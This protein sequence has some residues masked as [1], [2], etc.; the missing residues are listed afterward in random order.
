M[1]AGPGNIQFQSWLYQPPSVPVY[2]RALIGKGKQNK[3][4]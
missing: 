4:K 1:L 3:A 2:G